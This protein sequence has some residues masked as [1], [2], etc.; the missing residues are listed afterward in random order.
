MNPDEIKSWTLAASAAIATLKEALSLLPTG[1][2]RDEAERTLTRAEH[3]MKQAEAGVAQKLGL[4]ICPRCWPPEIM[5]IDDDDI[6]KCRSCKKPFPGSGNGK[7]NV[8]TR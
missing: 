5:L 6:L 1:A 3:E 8:R 7:M 2:K 4:E